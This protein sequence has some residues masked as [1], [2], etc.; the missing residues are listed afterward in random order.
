MSINVPDLILARDV[1]ERELRALQDLEVVGSSFFNLRERAQKRQVQVQN[2]L[3]WVRAQLRH[4]AAQE[5]PCCGERS[6]T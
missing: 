1:L 4:I 3:A 6:Q 2:D 5:Q